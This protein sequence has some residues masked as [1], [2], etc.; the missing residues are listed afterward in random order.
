MTKCIACGTSFKASEAI[1][2][3]WRDPNRSFG[4]PKCGTFYV[5]DMR[6]RHSESLIGGLLGGGVLGPT[7]LLFA[8]ALGSN[9]VKTMVL[10]GII[11]IAVWCVIG[12]R[13]INSKSELEVS[14]Y[15]RVSRGS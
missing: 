11:F 15:R 6:P 14:P 10:T 1:C 4:C 2:D 8:D 7:V 13:I 12:I 3:D 9:N 5:K